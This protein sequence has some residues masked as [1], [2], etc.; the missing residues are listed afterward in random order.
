MTLPHSLIL[1][2]GGCSWLSQLPPP[3]LFGRYCYETNTILQSN[4]HTLGRLRIK[5]ELAKEIKENR[6]VKYFNN[7]TSHSPLIK[8]ICKRKIVRMWATGKHPYEWKDII[9]KWTDWSLSTSPRDKECWR[10]TAANIRWED[11]NLID[12]SKS[13]DRLNRV[14]NNAHGSFFQF[15]L[16]WTR[17]NCVSIHYATCRP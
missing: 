16:V 5:N 6:H 9:K 3:P 7:I 12:W 13:C 8:T 4:A 17:T 10:S 2:H 1:M 15:K 11:N 14:T